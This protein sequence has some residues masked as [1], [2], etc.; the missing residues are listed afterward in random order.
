[1]QNNPVVATLKI[2]QKEIRELIKS[3]D[4]VLEFRH[5]LN[6]DPQSYDNHSRKDLK[7]IGQTNYLLR[8]LSRIAKDYKINYIQEGNELISVDLIPKK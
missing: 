5:Q 8:L 6:L 1:M 2:S 4:E 3:N 7:S